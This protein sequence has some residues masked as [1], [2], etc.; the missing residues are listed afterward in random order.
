MSSLVSLFGVALIV[1]GLRD[2]FQQLFRPSGGGVLSRSLMRLVWR[3][4]RRSAAHRPVVLELAGPFTL[5]AVIATWS[6][7]VWVGWA[8]LYWPR[9]PEEFVLQAGLASSSQGD[10]LDALYL[11]L[12]TL[13][14]LGYGDIVPTSDPLRMLAPLEGLVGFALLTAALSWVLSLYPAL[15]RRRSLAREATLIEESEREV[16]EVLERVGAEEAARVLGELAE[17]VVVVGGDL[18]QFPVTYYFYT[19]EERSSLP[20]VMPYL[21]HLAERAGGER[22]HPRVRLRA[23]MLRGAI[24]DLSDR[25]GSKAFLNLPDASAEEVFK[26][27]AHDH[28]HGHLH[29]EPRRERRKEEQ[30]STKKTSRP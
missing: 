25:I 1:A 14:T 12:V 20:L 21:L 3:G 23:G 6:L 30:P 15:S 13:T 18:V 22:F 26:A 8:L 7:L 27:Y 29:H 9:L 11:S 10:F 5:L 17:R 19:S 24:G 16:G 2:I 28:L 4:F